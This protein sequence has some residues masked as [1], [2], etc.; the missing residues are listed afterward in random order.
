MGSVGCLPLNYIITK[1]FWKRKKFLKPN[2]RPVL[3]LAFLKFPCR[4]S[5]K[6]ITRGK[7]TKALYPTELYP[8]ELDLWSSFLLSSF[9]LSCSFS[10]EGGTQN[11]TG[12]KGFA[13][14]CLTTWPCH[15]IF[16]IKPKEQTNCTDVFPFGW[17]L[18]QQL[19]PTEPQ[20]QPTAHEVGSGQ[21]EAWTYGKPPKWILLAPIVWVELA[22]TGF[23]PVT[24]GLWVPCSTTKLL[25][26]LNRIVPKI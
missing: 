6:P 18:N 21:S 11:R 4:K 7:S 2:R 25:S 17:N 3:W 9:L 15:L 26:Q 16:W 14:L 1:N 12:D 20:V 13:I 22:Q 19:E 24:L 5:T 23:E 8:R 10:S